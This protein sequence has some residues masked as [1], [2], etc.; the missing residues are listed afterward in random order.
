MVQCFFTIFEDKNVA[1]RTT[2]LTDFI[3]KIKGFYK[4]GKRLAIFSVFGR[5]MFRRPKV[6]A[7]F[8]LAKKVLEVYLS[9]FVKDLLLS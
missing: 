4:D 3:A 1:L 7:F 8:L 2:V 6:V 5:F 9:L